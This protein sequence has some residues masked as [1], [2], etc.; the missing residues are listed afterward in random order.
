MPYSAASVANEFLSHSFRDKRPITPMKMQ[1][2]VYFAHGYTLVECDRP[3]VDEAFE[4]WKFGPVLPSLYHECKKYGN[5]PIRVYLHDFDYR[6]ESRTPAPPPDHPRKIEIIKFVWVTYGPE[7]AEGLS[8]WTHVKGGPWD[9]I[10]SGGMDIPR[11]KDIPNEA[12]KKYFL[13]NMYDE[14]APQAP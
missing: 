8:D 6:R 14:Q 1:K 11:N 10:T 13:E 7:T 12:I 2:L 5:R 3:L 9:Q 4:A